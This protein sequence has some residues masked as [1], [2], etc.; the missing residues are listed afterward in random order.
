MLIESWALATAGAV[1]GVLLASWGVRLLNHHV[2][3]LVEVPFF[4]RF[5]LNAAILA[6]TALAACLAALVAGIV[7]ALRA[8]RTKIEAALKDGSRGD[9]GLRPGRLG[10]GLVVVQ[11]ALAC[12]LVIAAAMMAENVV[13][14]RSALTSDPA[15]LLIGR[16]ELD[17]RSYPRNRTDPVLPTA[18][19]SVQATPGVAAAAISSRDFV[20][21][22]TFTRF[23]KE[24]KRTPTRTKSRTWLEVVSAGVLPGRAGSGARGPPVRRNGPSGRAD[25]GGSER[26]FCAPALAGGEP[27]GQTAAP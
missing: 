14:A 13:R 15:S 18:A 26:Q 16:I 19:G 10:R 2:L 22:G 3:G 24:G 1:A 7:P 11:V 6:V 12:A 9:S 20:N 21:S 23:E 25:H 5:E 27:G 17:E 4:V 8:G